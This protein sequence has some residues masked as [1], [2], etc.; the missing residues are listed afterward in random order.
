VS[1]SIRDTARVKNLSDRASGYGI[2][3]ATVDATDV[4]AV[5]RAIAEAAQR[6]RSGGGATLVELKA[7]RWGGQTLKDP[8]RARTPE[9]LDAMR[10]KC[11]IATLRGQLEEQGLIDAARFERIIADACAQIAAGEAKARSYAPLPANP[12]KPL[13]PL[14][15]VYAS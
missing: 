12:A 15:N 6:A 14:L 5:Q 1:T 3:G 13:A 4:L 8:N 10:E 2:P 11:P 7:F 9:Q